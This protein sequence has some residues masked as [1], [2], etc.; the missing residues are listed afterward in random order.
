MSSDE[1]RRM[2]AHFQVN[3]PS[4]YLPATSSRGET[5]RSLYIKGMVEQLGTDI[6][7]A[8][9]TEHAEVVQQKNTAMNLSM[10]HVK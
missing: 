10:K 4:F 1:L 8:A 6:H 9:I 3:H 7:T 2:G 5:A